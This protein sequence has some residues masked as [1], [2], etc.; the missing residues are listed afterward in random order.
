MLREI[1]E[2]A[3]LREQWDALV[4]RVEQPQVF[5]TYEWALA[6]SRAYSETLRPLLFLAYDASNS[7]CGV[8]ALASNAAGRDA[9]FLCATTGDYCDFLSR[10]EE[11]VLFVSAVLGQLR[12]QG[13]ERIALANLPAD[14]ASVAAI[15]QAARQH[16]FFCFARKAYVC[17]QVSLARLERRKDGKPVAPGQKRLRRFVKAMASEAPVR[18]DHSRSWDA[19]APILP[20]FIQAHVARF[21]DIGR[22]SNLASKRRRLFLAELAR[23][24]SETQWLILSR[25]VTRERVAAW[26]YGFQ[27]H[28]TWFWYQPTLDSNVENYWPGFCLLTQAIQEA[29]EIPELKT[30]DLGL[31]SEAYKA[32][33]ANESRETLYVTMHDSLAEHVGTILRYRAAETVRTFPAVERLAGALRKEIRALRQRVRAQ[34]VRPVLVCAGRRLLQPLWRRDE[35]FFFDWQNRGPAPA[36]SL[37]VQLR[38]L[39]IGILAVAT[40]EC[41]DDES[42]LDY[43]LRSAKRLRT[44]G[45]E[46]FALTTD[47]GRPLHFVWVAPFDGFC[48]PDL[49]ATLQ[50]SPDCVMLFDCWT[51]AALRG[52]GYYAQSVELIA[53][54]MRANGKQPW[55]F[56]AAANVA[57]I[58]GLAK[59][60]FQRR[61][62]RVRKRLLWW[63]TVT[64]QS[65]GRGELSAEEVAVHL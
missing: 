53:E 50:A 33:F 38:L 34:G 41:E 4:L 54:K 45:M 36:N 48:S 15:R 64:R 23:L 49:N 47:D 35:L 56:S 24:L 31:G 18:F 27:F 5:Y 25:M 57:A 37:N 39:D 19:V 2:D 63:Q 55:T 62:S 16:R 32:K 52:R 22:I 12:S 3:G 10:P 42:T 13:I 11:R 7:L 30:V 28:D 1:P 29:T 58:R 9:S 21:L 43:L 46:G 14:S 8:A 44:G 51:P 65:S 26:H 61:Y 60:G 17:A 20:Q 59:T 6:V 40:M